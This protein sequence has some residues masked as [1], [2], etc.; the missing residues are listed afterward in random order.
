MA[1]STIFQL[2]PSLEGIN[3]GSA[4][5]MEYDLTDCFV[6]SV[7]DYLY[8]ECN[9]ED[10]FDW[11][12]NH[13]SYRDT[14]YGAGSDKYLSSFYSNKKIHDEDGLPEAFIVFHKGFKSFYFKRTYEAFKNNAEAMTLEKF[15]DG[16]TMF[17][18][19]NI[20]EDRYSFYIFDECRSYGTLDNWI[21]DYIKDDKESKYYL[22]TVFGYHH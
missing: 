19:T 20:I 17:G 13:L 22:G 3:D 8:D 12:V 15:M 10:A 11:L 1:G 4:L 6:P 14:G 2:L 7:A 5:M 9:R 16:M 21:R 18:F